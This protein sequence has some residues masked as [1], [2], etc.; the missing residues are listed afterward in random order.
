MHTMIVWYSVLKCLMQFIVNMRYW[1][2]AKES[3]K[4]EQNVLNHSPGRRSAIVIYDACLS[5][6]GDRF[7]CVPDV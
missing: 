7:V 5:T 1:S 2:R 4:K 6:S 3:A